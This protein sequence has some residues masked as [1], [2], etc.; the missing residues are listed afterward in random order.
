M[1]RDTRPLLRRGQQYSI[2]FWK[3]KYMF[4]NNDKWCNTQYLL[5]KK[6]PL[7]CGYNEYAYNEFM[8]AVKLFSFILVF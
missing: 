3:G 5:Q 8:L 4:K 2:S 7:K 6:T 1:P